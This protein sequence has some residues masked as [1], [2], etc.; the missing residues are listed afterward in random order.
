MALKYTVRYDLVHFCH[1]AFFVIFFI[2]LKKC[3][4]K[5]FE[6]NWKDIYLRK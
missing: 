3:R 5:N 1:A 4:K 6:N 2:K